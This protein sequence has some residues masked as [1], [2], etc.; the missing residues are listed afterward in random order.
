MLNYIYLSIQKK[1]KGEKKAK[2][3]HKKAKKKKKKWGKKKKK[4]EEKKKKIQNLNQ[5]HNTLQEF[6]SYEHFH[7]KNSTGQNDAR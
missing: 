1:Q 6:K 3:K 2:N 7:Q 5:M 4:E